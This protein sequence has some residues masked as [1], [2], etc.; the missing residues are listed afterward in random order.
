MF[1]RLLGGAVGAG[2]VLMSLVAVGAEV[3]GDDGATFA[4]VTVQSKYLKKFN[5]AV[6]MYPDSG[7]VG[8]QGA[9]FLGLRKRVLSDDD[10]S[11]GGDDA[12]YYYY[13]NKSGDFVYVD[14]SSMRI[15]PY[16]RFDGG[17]PSVINFDVGWW[18]NWCSKRG[19]EVFVGMG[20]L[21]KKQSAMVNF[22]GDGGRGRYDSATD[23]IVPFPA[24]TP[25]G[26][27]DPVAGAG[28]SP[29]RGYGADPVT[30]YGSAP[31]DRKP[32][33]RD[34]QGEYGLDDEKRQQ[35]LADRVGSDGKRRAPSGGRGRLDKESMALTLITN[36]MVKNRK[37]GQIYKVKPK[38]KDRS[39]ES[40]NEDLWDST[41]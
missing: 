4:D 41:D 36:D 25:S 29:T 35:A 30:G 23:E 34:T 16:M 3:V 20:V 21:T 19:Y 13:D 10:Y 8:L 27:P 38:K 37:Y 1:L 32:G 15:P 11:S 6:S 18:E 7:D 31:G 14:G 22:V 2:L 24:F 17:V 40:D 5:M 39:C 9:M 12:D 28:Q 26:L 33:A